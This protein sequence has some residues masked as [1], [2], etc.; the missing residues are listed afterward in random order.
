MFGGEMWVVYEDGR[1]NL[2]NE[3]M[4]SDSSSLLV[5]RMTQGI[6]MIIVTSPLQ[7]LHIPLR[8]QRRF[9]SFRR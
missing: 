4:Y 6:W 1:K 5:V 9:F 2:I 3:V 7:I 8:H